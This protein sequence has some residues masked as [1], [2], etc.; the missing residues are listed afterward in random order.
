M[1]RAPGD[2]VERL[3]FDCGQDDRGGNSLVLALHHATR[4]RH[5]LLLTPA[6]KNGLAGECH[7]ACFGLS[8][9]WL[10]GSD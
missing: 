9:H 3:F 10:S 7:P 4:R 8:A 6:V 5:R 1:R 2:D